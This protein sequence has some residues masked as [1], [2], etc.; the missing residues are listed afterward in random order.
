VPGFH[1][2]PLRRWTW[3]ERVGAGLGT[4]AEARSVARMWRGPEPLF[5]GAV[6]I[7][8]LSTSHY[9]NIRPYSMSHTTLKIT[10]P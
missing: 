1:M 8:S 7:C 2:P 6:D 3:G 9:R 10:P 5:H 4:G